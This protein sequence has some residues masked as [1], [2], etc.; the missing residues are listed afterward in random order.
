MNE[1]LI[2][3]L[4]IIDTF[5]D[6]NKFENCSLIFNEYKKFAPCMVFQPPL[7]NTHRLFFAGRIQC[8]FL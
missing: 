8:G 1:F 2:N 5:H 6:F 4:G 7:W 3:M